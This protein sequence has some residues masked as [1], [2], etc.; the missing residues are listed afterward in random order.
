MAI[1]TEKSLEKWAAEIINAFDT[2]K[3]PLT[4]GVVKIAEREVL[5]PEQIKRLVETTN[6][7]AFMDRFNKTNGNDRYDASHFETADPDSAI[8]RLIDAAKD[9]MD[10]V[11]GSCHGGEPTSPLTDLAGELPVTRPDKEPLSMA[12][13]EDNFEQASKPK[14]KG[15]VMIMRLRK[16]AGELNNKLYENKHKFQDNIQKLATLF[17]R[18]SG[19]SFEEFEKDAFYKWG[20]DVAPFLQILR[21]ALR[22]K[23]ADYNHDALTKV[24]RVVDLRKQEMRLIKEAMACFSDF[25]KYSAGLKTVNN[26]RVSLGDRI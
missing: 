19:P 14:I 15:S 26:Y 21:G 2:A 20:S 5:N 18:V 9:V 12:G 3:Q 8:Q 23:A 24:A 11:G 22:K 13:P 4:D 6:N 10:S 25:E 7:M 1:L 17:T 16:T